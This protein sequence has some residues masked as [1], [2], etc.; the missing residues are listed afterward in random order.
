MRAPLKCKLVV[1]SLPSF[2]MK[3]PAK[4]EKYRFKTSDTKL[5]PS[6]LEKNISKEIIVSKPKNMKDIYINTEPSLLP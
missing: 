4:L 5:E 2:A 1:K 3:T 6:E